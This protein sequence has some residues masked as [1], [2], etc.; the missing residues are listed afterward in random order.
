[1]L[2]YALLGIGG[3]GDIAS[4]WLL[5]IGMGVGGLAGA[6]IGARFQARL[7]ERLLGRGLGALALSLGLYYAPQAL[8]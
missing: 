1:M 6:Y 4:D 5:G 3:E 7:P 2:T 8:S